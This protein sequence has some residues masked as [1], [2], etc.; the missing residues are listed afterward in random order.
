MSHSLKLMSK[1]L[2]LNYFSKFFLYNKV[3]FLYLTYDFEKYIARTLTP[4]P[5]MHQQLFLKPVS[6]MEQN[7]LYFIS[8][9]F[10]SQDIF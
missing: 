10:S 2:V 3:L 4:N 9:I 1:V 7:T 6:K 8:F 5:G